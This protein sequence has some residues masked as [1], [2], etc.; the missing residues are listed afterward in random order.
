[1]KISYVGYQSQT[2]SLF[3]KK[4]YFTVLLTPQTDALKEVVLNS[5]NPANDIIR[6]V[7]LAKDNNNPLKKLKT[8]QYK[9]YNKLLVTANPDSI[10]GKIDTVF[11]DFSTKD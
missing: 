8:F 10:S 3:E 1:M 4:P 9:T 6:K 5:E 7:I 2:I 11:A